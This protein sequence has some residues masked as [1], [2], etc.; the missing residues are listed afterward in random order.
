M[1]AS[2]WMTGW[3][4]GSINRSIDQL[5]AGW[6]AGLV[7][8][9]S[10]LLAVLAMMPGL[11]WLD[12]CKSGVVDDNGFVVD[13]IRVESQLD[14]IRPFHKCMHLH[15][16]YYCVKAK[17]HKTHTIRVA[18]LSRAFAPRRVASCSSCVRA[19]VRA[20]VQ[21]VHAMP[22]MDG[23]TNQRWFLLARSLA[24]WCVGTARVFVLEGAANKKAWYVQGRGALSVQITTVVRRSKSV[25]QK[26]CCFVYCCCDL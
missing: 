4:D 18:A 13:W 25:C 11:A 8:C 22:R 15:N 6:S 10:C 24:C 20:Y 16:T 3:I 19:C 7:A 14:S 2:D 12:G 9:C 1:V 5:L 17:Y 21:E 26:F 23:W